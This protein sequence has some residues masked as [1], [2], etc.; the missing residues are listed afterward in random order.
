MIDSPNPYGSYFQ[1]GA[2]PGVAGGPMGFDSH[3]TRSLGGGG[4]HS[5]TQSESILSK[6][7]DRLH[8]QAMSEALRSDARAG[9]MNDFVLDQMYGNDKGRRNAATAAIGGAGNMREWVSSILNNPGVSGFT[10]GDIRAVR[11]G[12]SA[13]AGGGGFV[14]VAGAGQSQMLGSGMVQNAAAQQVFEAVNRRF[15]TQSGAS[16]MALTNGMNRDQVGGIMSM[17]SQSGAFSGLDMGKI[18]RQGEKMKFDLNPGAVDKIETFVKESTKALSSLVDVFGDRSV[19]ELATLAHRI[20][21]LDMSRTSNVTTMG[22]RISELKATAQTYGMDTRTVLETAGNVTAMGVQMGLAAHTSGTISQSATTQAIGQNVALRGDPGFFRV[23]G[24]V[25]ELASQHMRDQ[26]A[27]MHDPLGSRIMA[28]EM[29]IETGS[30]SGTGVAQLRSAAKG[31]NGQNVGAFDQLFS[32]STGGQSVSAMIR[33]FGDGARIAS[34][35]SPEGQAH[36]TAA[37][38]SNMKERQLQRLEFKASEA[39]G[40]GAAKDITALMGTFGAK[41]LQ[42]MTKMISSGDREGAIKL[43]MSDSAVV[44]DR[45]QAEGLMGHIDSLQAQTGGRSGAVLMQMDK[46]ARGDAITAGLTSKKEDMAHLRMQDQVM[47]LSS[48]ESRQLTGVFNRGVQGFLEMAGGE[49]P[50]HKLALTSAL[51]PKSVKGMDMTS[52][53]FLD[54]KSY[55]TGPDGK[56]TKGSAGKFASSLQNLVNQDPEMAMRL[57]VSF[58]ALNA[59]PEK[60]ANDNFNSIMGQLGDPGQRQRIFQGK[61]A[62]QGSAGQLFWADTKKI[63]DGQVGAAAASIGIFSRSG[64]TDE[65]TK[66]FFKKANDRLI[67]GKMN[68]PASLGELYAFIEKKAGTLDRDSLIKLSRVDAR[69][70]Q[71]ALQGIS[72]DLVKLEQLDSSATSRD[73]ERE[74]KIKDLR[75]RKQALEMEGVT[76]PGGSANKFVGVLQLMDGNGLS[77]K[78]TEKK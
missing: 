30:V 58:K 54:S 21:G 48:D 44:K 55:E 63:V 14:N 39:L 74:K 11:M 60:F 75:D 40:V 70:A 15:W 36:A 72:D 12:A 50:M 67:G 32:Q 31:L 7:M 9:T 73:P 53:V 51:S 52:Q 42:Q 28:A 23:T 29:A 69:G 13:I 66:E 25:Q 57:G 27:M 22:K 20:T 2:H 64:A 37:I 33:T 49:T 62:A 35:L 45:A 34:Q 41:D 4:G 17:G 43:A 65:P 26:V 18:S 24:S 46:L 77:I 47:K 8:Q 76:T 3:M 6:G 61:T 78:V 59:D 1:F 10:G 68:D 56:L 71:H 16:N 19:G 5:P 38:N